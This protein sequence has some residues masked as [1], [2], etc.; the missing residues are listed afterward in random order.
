MIDRPAK[1]E[2]GAAERAGLA[3]HL[4]A[5]RPGD[6][7]DNRRAEAAASCRPVPAGVKADKGSNTRSRSSGA[8]PGPS[9]S[10]SNEAREP[11]SVRLTATRWLL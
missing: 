6:T 5:H 4:A 8:I 3:A 9:S 7:V 11:C 2:A 10:T 1:A